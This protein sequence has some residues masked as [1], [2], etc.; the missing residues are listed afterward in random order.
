MGEIDFPNV[1]AW[2]RLTFQTFQYGKE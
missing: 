2:E 1:S